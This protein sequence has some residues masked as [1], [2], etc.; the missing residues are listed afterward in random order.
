M[1]LSAPITTE[2]PLLPQPTPPLVRLPE[3]PAL[4]LGLKAAH[5]LTI[6]GEI[7][8][9][10]LTAA[11]HALHEQA[12]M[13]AHAPYAQNR[14]NCQ[15]HAFD[16]LELYLFVYPV[17][18][19]VPTI[20]GVAKALGI[21]APS[22]SEEEPETL[23]GCAHALL[24]D[25]T[26]LPE[27][28]RE[29]LA[30]I[31]SVM[32]QRGKGWVWTPYVMA[33]L[34]YT[35][36][37]AFMPDA[38]HALAIWNKLP[39]WSERAPPAPPSHFPVT[40]DETDDALRALLREGPKTAEERTEQRDYARAMADVF[41]TK[42]DLEEPHV[43]LAEAGTGVG[44]TLGYLAPA[45]VWAKKNEGAVW[46]STFTRNLQQQLEEE[47]TRLYPD[48]ELRERKV[49]V[50]KG[51]ENYLC[52]LNFEDLAASAPLARSVTAAI[53]AGIM[54]RWIMETEDG[55]FTGKS[56][57]GWVQGLLG[58]ANTN[59]LSLKSGEC[60]F[61][62]CDHYNRCFK[63]RAVRK[64]RHAE[65][66][67]ANH[68][69]VMIQTAMAGV[70]DEL[71]QRYIF[72]EGHHLFSAA[73]SAY[74]AHLTGRETH[75]LRRWILGS[76]DGVR[77]R[78]RGLKKR[79]EEIVAAYPEDEKLLLEALH[80]ARTLPAL[81]WLKR[82]SENAPQGPIETLLLNILH[83]VQARA[84]HADAYYSLETGTFPL[85]SAIADAIPAARQALFS[86]QAPLL[87][88]AASLN[89]R[90]QNAEEA[91]LME[92]DTRR[93]IEALARSLERRGRMQLESW[94][95]V[96]DALEKG[97]KHEQFIDWLEIEK[98][99]G[100]V[101]D[102]G[103]YRHYVDPMKPFAASLLPHAHGVGI[104]S[105]TLR[106]KTGDDAHDWREAER[107]TGVSYLTTQPRDFAVTSPFNYAEQ[108][109]IFILNDI[110]KTDLGQMGAALEAL[111]RAAGGGGLGLFTA[112][113][114]LR[115]VHRHLSE[116]LPFP[117]YAQH[118]DAID[119]GTLIDMFRDEE[120]ACLLGTDAMRDGVDVPGRSLRLIAFDRVPWPRPTLLH[121]ARRA[122]FGGKAYDE[123]VTRMKLQ[124]AFG[125]LI[126]NSKDKGVF[127]M[128]DSAMP[129][130]LLSAF[131]PAVPVVKVGL[132]EAARE[133][134]AFLG[135]E[136]HE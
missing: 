119:S 15:L 120:H 10:K 113:Q 86:L 97:E 108:A 112:I 38:R 30:L 17:K 100:R 70:E 84:S 92:G 41:A 13:V 131:P 104:T 22:T 69:L 85:A 42:D 124:Q 98:I 5:L 80:H 58:Y 14:L 95:S 101:Y 43:V 9:M 34:G 82:L 73:D 32:G 125:R 29:R 57:P 81:G 135:E 48:P 121:K 93:R 76:E 55:D 109:R 46:I 37:P 87:K 45:S 27:K 47:L 123:M 26:K 122:A 16:I 75:D 50:R 132:S 19:A 68:A 63:E 59:G 74:A 35:Y 106:D 105:A 31:A 133:I 40:A 25:L 94:L 66:V 99:D 62:A 39:E 118:V 44:K 78:N 126:R 52:L 56:F 54:A 8:T 96:L 127:V 60:I 77:K 33:A 116:T 79:A 128:M 23:M 110:S 114:R 53:S 107:Q 36:D 3:V 67:V 90:L 24:D 1:S 89:K 136:T 6:D 71:P 4:A 2:L 129:S 11:S 88:L 103:V 111:F 64:S 18:F 130:R 91:E 72:D 115:A 49:A 21:V 65:M 134:R 51:R 117:L 83:Q 28:Q 7:K 102:L 61:S 12:C 20:K